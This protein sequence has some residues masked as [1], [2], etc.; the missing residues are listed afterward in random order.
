MGGFMSRT[1]YL[2]PST[3]HSLRII[4]YH[5]VAIISKMSMRNMEYVEIIVVGKGAYGR[6][7]DHTK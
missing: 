2:F 6:R 5:I 1:A 4:T 3:G 7:S